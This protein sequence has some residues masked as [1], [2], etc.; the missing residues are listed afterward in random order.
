MNNNNH[1]FLYFFL[2]LIYIPGL[3]L[4]TTDKCINTSTF[5]F[6]DNSSF[7]SHAED[8]VFRL[9]VKLGF[10]VFRNK[11]CFPFQV[12]RHLRS[13]TWILFIIITLYVF[14]PVVAV[15][16]TIVLCMPPQTVHFYPPVESHSLTFI[17][18]CLLALVPQYLLQRNFFFQ[19][20]RMVECFI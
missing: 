17:Y 5:R 3:T 16:C 18:K 12:R 9:K 10:F 7:E 11:S 6:T 19:F 20:S 15:A 2:Y 4:L 8:P 14:L 1:T 13:T